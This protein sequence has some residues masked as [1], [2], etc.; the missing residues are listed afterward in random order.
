MDSIA[1]R[2]GLFND[3]K[4]LENTSKSPDTEWDY[5]VAVEYYTTG[6]YQDIQH[7]WAEIRKSHSTV[8]IEGLALPELGK[9]IKS[10]TLA[11]SP[12]SWIPTCEDAKYDI[13]KPFIGQWH[14][15]LVEAEDEQLYGNLSIRLTNE[16]CHLTKDFTM[17]T[18]AFSYQTLGYYNP[19][20]DT[21]METYT[22]S[23]GGY[24][25]YE[26]IRL[27]PGISDWIETYTFSNGGYAIYEWKWMN[28]EVILELQE[29]SFPS[30][31]L[32][33]NRWTNAKKHSFQIISEESKDGR[34][35]DR[36]GQYVH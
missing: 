13:L 1:V 9:I 32:K 17:L 2:K 21:W 14:E 33:R 26:C 30:K 15:Y 24:A 23:N 4:L 3:Y 20:T 27:H 34:T 5:I 8:L 35:C 12:D 22:F 10:E 29:S 18:S 6:A 7:E 31:K 16:G 28:E 25:I 19:I 11:T 36:P